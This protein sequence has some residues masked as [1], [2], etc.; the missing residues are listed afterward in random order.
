MSTYQIAKKMAQGN[1]IKNTIVILEGWDE[2][3]I[4][5]YL[6]E[7]NICSKKEF[8]ELVNVDYS[9]K[10]LFLKDKPKT[11]DL[12]GY[13]FPDTYEVSKNPDCKEVILAMLSNFDK[14]LTEDMR[15]QIQKQGKSIFDVVI[16]ASI[17]EKE[18]RIESDKKMVSSILWKRISINMPLQVDAT[19]NY[20]TGK[21]DPSV[22]I[23]DT[24]IDSPYNTYKYR[25]L[26]M[27]P[28]SNPGIGSILAAMN[29]VKTDYLFYLSNG[30]TYYSKTLDEHNEAKAKYLN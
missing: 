16:M 10:F 25:G 11:A 2:A 7:K 30:A 28:I 18:V 1:V 19:V 15:S 23:K 6:E 4:A 12:E 21:S 13:L 22:L 17:I 5:H 24:K 27:G 14:K 3:D 9:G 20:I 29:P 8:T 26:P